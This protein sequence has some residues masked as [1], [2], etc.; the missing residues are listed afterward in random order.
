LLKEIDKAKAEGER[1]KQICLEQ[2]LVDEDGNPT[3]FEKQEQQTFMEE[4]PEVD[5]G[6][7]RSEFVK[8]PVLLPRPGSK[9]VQSFRNSRPKAAEEISHSAGD[10]I[11]Q[12]LLHQLR[13]SPL[14]VNLLART[15]EAEFGHIKGEEWQFDVLAFWYRDGARKGASAY[16]VYSSGIATQAPRRSR[17]SART[18]SD[19]SDRYSLRIAIRTSLLQPRSESKSASLESIEPTQQFGV[20]LPSP[21]QGPKFSQST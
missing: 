4:A 13:S 6:S 17:Y 14:D 7:E 15:F 10:H 21:I 1:L 9:E 2:G 16:R 12:W 5:S 8:F 18:L 11:N 19:A 3:D 20:L